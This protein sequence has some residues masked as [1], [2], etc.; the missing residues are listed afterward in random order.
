[1]L[2]E[3]DIRL[4]DSKIDLAAMKSAEA[5][6]NSIHKKIDEA[7]IV[8]CATCPTAKTVATQRD[9]AE[10]AKKMFRLGRSIVSGIIVGVVWLIKELVVLFRSST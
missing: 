6:K 2:D 3:N 10:G 4:L 8:R 5:V 9:E 7:L 1:V